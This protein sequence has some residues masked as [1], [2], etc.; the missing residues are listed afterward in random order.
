MENILINFDYSWENVINTNGK[1]YYFP[2]NTK[3]IPKIYATSA[4]YKWEINKDDIVNCIY[5]GETQKLFPD[6]INGYLKPGPTQKTNIYINNLFQEYLKE[7][8]FIELKILKIENNNSIGIKISNDE[9]SNKYIR[10]SIENL[11][12]AKYK[13]EGIKLLNK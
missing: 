4:I 11:L 10:K 12:I 7:K 9:F 8:C 6:R 3:L 1:I 13:N 5:I 2:D